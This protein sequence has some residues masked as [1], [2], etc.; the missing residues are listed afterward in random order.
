MANELTDAGEILALDLLN[1]GTQ[2]I[3]GP[4]KLA[5]MTVAGTDST[6]GTEVT[7]GSYARQTVTFSAGINPTANTNAISFTGMPAATV[8]GFEIYD[9]SATPK[10]IWAGAVTSTAFSAGNT[11]TVAIGAVTLALN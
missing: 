11:A 2:T 9:S 3:T 8:V 1:G 6:A 4:M 7:G 10:R 5:L